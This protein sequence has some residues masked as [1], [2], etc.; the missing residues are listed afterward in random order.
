M[1]KKN[2]VVAILAI[3]FIFIPFIVFAQSSP[4]DLRFGVW[5]TGNLLR[6]E[7]WYSVRTTEPCF[8]IVDTAGDFDTYLEAY[9]SSNNLISEDDDSGIDSNARL[10]IY[11]E[12]GR[13][14]LFKISGYDSSDRGPYR[15]LASMDPVSPETDRNTDRSRA[16]ALSLGEANPIIFRTPGESRWYRYEKSPAGSTLVVR[17]RGSLDTNLTLYDSNG[18]VIDSDDDSGDN[19]NALVAES[20]HSGTIYIEVKTYKGRMGRTSLHAELQ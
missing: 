18:N 2:Y 10:E 12:S 5:V 19:Y 8:L 1:Q 20:D 15:I 11:A 4:R 6:G 9:D 13:T 3:M 7:E 17:T 14:Y 16:V